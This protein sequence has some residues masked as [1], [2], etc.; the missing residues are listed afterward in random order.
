VLRRYRGL[1][2]KLIDRV[3]REKP[4]LENALH[5]ARGVLRNGAPAGRRG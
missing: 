4:V 5:W 3:A 2:Q 1:A